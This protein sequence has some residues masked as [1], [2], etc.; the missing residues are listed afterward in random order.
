MI[1][2]ILGLTA[3]AALTMAMLAKLSRNAPD[4][5]GLQEGMLAPLPASPNGVSSQSSKPQHAV[6]PFSFKKN[7]YQALLKLKAVLSEFPG[8]TLVTSD[9]RY[10]R[11]EFKSPLFGFVDDGEFLLDGSVIQVRSA[12]RVGK[13]DLG[14]NRKRIE[15]LRGLFEGTDP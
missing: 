8:T 6:A 4:G 12:S 10:V 15:H 2:T 1:W 9:A 5:M 7:P 13:H 3:G 14:A 11:A